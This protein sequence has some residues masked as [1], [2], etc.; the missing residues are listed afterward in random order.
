MFLFIP[1]L[2]GQ[3]ISGCLENIDLITSLLLQKPFY[4]NNVILFQPNPSDF[5]DKQVAKLAKTFFKRG[6]TFGATKSYI[7]A[8]DISSVVICA[9]DNSSLE[10]IS[11][12]IARHKLGVR[13][14]TVVLYKTQIQTLVD[15]FASK[16]RI[17]Q[18]V[19]FVKLDSQSV[20]EMY[21]VNNVNIVNVLGHWKRLKWLPGQAESF[22]KRRRNL[23]G[24][25]K[26]NLLL[27]D[28]LHLYI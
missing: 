7:K 21:S 20:H 14:P 1:I 6:N 2:S 3:E 19:Y 18:E 17:D 24:I 22:Y 5:N 27:T 26:V 23:Q 4:I 16:I 28:F 15:I 10:A 8:I 12:Q 13:K 25:K 11:E 9:N